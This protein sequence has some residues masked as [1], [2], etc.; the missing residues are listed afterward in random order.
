MRFRSQVLTAITLFVFV[1]VF[2]LRIQARIYGGGTYGSGV[3][4]GEDI[5][6]HVD[7]GSLPI[8]EAGCAKSPPG[9]APWLYGA[10]AQD[11][12]SILI[13]FTDSADPV[14]HYVLQY[15]LATNAYRW[16]ASN[17]GGKGV[18]TYLVSSLASD[19]TYHFRVSGANGC[20]NG[21]WSNDIEATTKKNMLQTGLASTLTIKSL[22]L[23]PDPLP[24]APSASLSAEQAST[25]AVLETKPVVYELTVHVIDTNKKA[26]V[27]ASVTIDPES[28]SHVTDDNGGVTFQKLTAGDKS[29]SISYQGKNAQSHIFLSGSESNRELTVT[30]EAVT[31]VATLKTSALPLYAGIAAL[32]VA[33]LGVLIYILR[34]RQ[35]SQL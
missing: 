19:T 28:A 16:G 21:M 7:T 35:T 9:N 15:G 22:E 31:A 12:H 5:P 23:K 1:L 34:K 3:Y 13:Y 30:V 6:V 25:S 18:R 32:I 27:G 29:V 17:I 20:A 14:D 26:L 8:P 11:D 4:G 33:L 2:P 24:E 10:I